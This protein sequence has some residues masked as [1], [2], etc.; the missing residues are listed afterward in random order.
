MRGRY[1]YSITPYIVGGFV[2]CLVIGTLANR[3][4]FVGIQAPNLDRLLRLHVRRPAQNQGPPE[5]STTSSALL[6]LQA[7]LHETQ[8]STVKSIRRIFEPLMSSSEK[9]AYWGNWWINLTCVGLGNEREDFGGPGAGPK[10]DDTRSIRN[11]CSSRVGEGR[12]GR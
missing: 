6:E 1:G 11:D 5:P 4:L 8:S 10:N 2:L 9:S 12:S 3:C 7:Q